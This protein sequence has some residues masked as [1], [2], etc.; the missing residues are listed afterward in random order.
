MCVRDM[1]SVMILFNCNL[2]GLGTWVE[3]FDAQIT[4]HHLNAASRVE[5]QLKAV[6]LCD[7]RNVLSLSYPQG[8]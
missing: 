8:Q 2:G 6:F 4:N 5:S 1:Y 3:T 7:E